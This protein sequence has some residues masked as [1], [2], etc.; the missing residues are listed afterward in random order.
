MT[1]KLIFTYSWCN[2]I[3]SIKKF[4]S[5][6][7]GL[8]LIWDTPET[9]AYKIHDHQLSFNLDNSLDT[10][11]SKFAEQLG[12]SGGT[13]HKTSWSL[14]CSKDE[15]DGIVLRA[16]E[17]NIPSYHSEPQWVGY[18]SFPILD[19]MNETIEITAPGPEP[20]ETE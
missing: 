13:E 14:E 15:F 18:W 2:D 16:K 6:I 3:Q 1:K 8:E 5:E 20:K 19:P 7:L 10:P 12:W 11:E 17:A 4:Y 9:I